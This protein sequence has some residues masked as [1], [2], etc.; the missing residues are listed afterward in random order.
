MVARELA[1]SFAASTSTTPGNSSSNNSSKGV[2]PDQQQSLVFELNQSG[3]YL[4]IKDQLKQ[5][6]LDLVQERYKTAGSTPDT[7]QVG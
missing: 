2:A 3:R 7:A 4:A 6:L 1:H 5:L